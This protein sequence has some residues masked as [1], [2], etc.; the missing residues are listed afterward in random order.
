[1][2]RITKSLMI[3]CVSAALLTSASLMAQ[4]APGGQGGGQGGPGGRPNFDPAQARQRMSEMMRERL[5]VTNDDEWKVLQDRIEKVS[6]L[7]RETGGGFGGGMGG[8]GGMMRPRNNNNND[9][10]GGNQPRRFG[11]EPTP[12]VAALEK[13]IEGKASTEELKAKLVS[14]REARKVSAAKLEK[15]QEDLK[16][17]L[18]VRQEAQLVLMGVLQ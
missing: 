13:A 7:R 16:K 2:K 5:E 12:E 4:P 10:A 15:A 6:T 1:M 8:M 18:N 9:N 14:V 3:A 17:V 11:P